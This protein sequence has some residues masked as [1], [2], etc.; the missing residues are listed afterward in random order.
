MS[1]IGRTRPKKGADFL[2]RR[3]CIQGRVDEVPHAT[4]FLKIRIDKV[5]GFSG[6]DAQILRQAER[7][8]SVYDTEV[9]DFGLAAMI[10][11]TIRGGT[12]KTCEAVSVWMSSPC[13]IGFHQ[14]RIFREMGQQP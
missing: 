14:Q 13:A 5:L 4:I 10:G 12:P 7:R 1:G 3:A 11:V 9:Y 8:K 6:L 2:S